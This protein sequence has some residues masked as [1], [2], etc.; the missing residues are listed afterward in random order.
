MAMFRI[1]SSDRNGTDTCATGDEDD[2][3]IGYHFKSCSALLEDI[4][5]RGRDAPLKYGQW[6]Q[7]D[8]YTACRLEKEQPPPGTNIPRDDTCVNISSM[9][10]NGD[11]ARLQVGALVPSPIASATFKVLARFESPDGRH[12][13]WND[14]GWSRGDVH[15]QIYDGKLI[16]GVNGNGN[17]AFNFKPQEDKVG[18]RGVS[19]ACADYH[20]LLNNPPT[21]LPPRP[22][23]VTFL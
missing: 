23:I 17:T 20:R 15:F 6:L 22:T 1:W 5:G 12:V 10:F 16:F 13:L 2:L 3:L 19:S 21:P 9:Y 7:S 8:V 18:Y 4:T 14:D 11:T